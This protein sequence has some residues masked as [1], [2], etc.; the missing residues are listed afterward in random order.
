[1]KA[2]K[3]WIS[4]INKAISHLQKAAK[5]RT[6][7]AVK[8]RKLQK[9]IERHEMD[10]RAVET[11]NEMIAALTAAN[12][13]PIYTIDWQEIHRQPPPKQPIRTGRNEQIAVAKQ[14]KYRP[15]YIDRILGKTA[16]KK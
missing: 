11:Y 6:R 14:Q 13:E 15:S 2:N 3:G 7:Q 1:M 10:I 16:L 5:T 9:K 4:R 12:K 8:H